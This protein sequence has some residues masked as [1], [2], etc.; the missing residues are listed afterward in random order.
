MKKKDKTPTGNQNKKSQSQTSACKVVGPKL[1]W[2]L[3]I[4]VAERILVLL[5]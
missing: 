1:K 5:S 3:N 4:A 2:V